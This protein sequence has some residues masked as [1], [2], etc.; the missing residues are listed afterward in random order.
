MIC[1]RCTGPNEFRCNGPL[2]N[3]EEFVAAF[4]VPD[5]APMNKPTAERVDIW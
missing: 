3:I 4:G 5:G 1:T 2:S